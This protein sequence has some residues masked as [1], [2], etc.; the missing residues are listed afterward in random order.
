MV[1]LK[2]RHQRALAKHNQY[3]DGL[4]MYF[5]KQNDYTGRQIQCLWRAS[6]LSVD[7][8]ADRLCRSKERAKDYCYGQKMTAKMRRKI[9]Q[10]FKVVIY[11]RMALGKDT[12]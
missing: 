7:D 8:V 4:L 11:E 10:F 3:F 9:A 2:R 12:E 5:G 6:R 1:N